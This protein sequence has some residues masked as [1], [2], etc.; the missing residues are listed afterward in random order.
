MR[1]LL[2]ISLLSG[3]LNPSAA[4]A[5]DCCNEASAEIAAAH[6]QSEDD[7]T[8]SCHQP[9][10]PTD[11]EINANHQQ[12]CE[13]LLG[14]AAICPVQQSAAYNPLPT[15]SY[16]DYTSTSPLQFNQPLIRPPIHA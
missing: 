12:Q 3:L 7:Q 13:C 14:V 8:M 2:I 9:D 15:D 11:K 16:P 1:L 5:D 4:L 6:T 10:D